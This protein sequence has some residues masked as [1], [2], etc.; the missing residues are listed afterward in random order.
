MP[1]LANC[2]APLLIAMA[3]HAV[4]SCGSVPDTVMATATSFQADDH[5]ML[6]RANPATLG[7]RRLSYQSA[8][9][10]DLGSFLRS[11]GNPDFVAEA[12][13]DGRRHMIFYY[14]K[15]SHAYASQTLRD[16]PHAMTFSGPYRITRHEVSLLKKLAAQSNPQ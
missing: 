11:R 14:L 12:A 10:P 3:T 9:Y 5:L 7:F 4:T 15:G 6:V 8:L 2:L 16:D 13:N 1:R